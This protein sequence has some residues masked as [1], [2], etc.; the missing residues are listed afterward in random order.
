MASGFLNQFLDLLGSPLGLLGLILGLVTV[1]RAKHSPRLAWFLVALCCFAASLSEFRDQFVLDA[2]DLVFPLEQL[3]SAG[4]PLSIVLLALLLWLSCITLSYK[5]WRQTFIPFAVWA[6]ATIQGLIFFK[7]AAFGSITFALLAILTFSGVVLM[8]RLGPARW[9]QDNHQFHLGVW[10]IATVSIIFLAVNGYQAL[11]DPYPITFVH[12]AF[13]GTTGNP[14]HA[15][16]LLASTIPCILFLSQVQTQKLWALFWTILLICVFIALFLTGS[17]TGAIMGVLSIGL[18]FRHSNRRVRIVVPGIL[19]GGI[20][21]I[22]L[23]PLL[24]QFH[25]SIDVS[26][27]TRQLLNVDN[28]RSQVWTALWR[29][30][31]TYPVFGIPLQGDRFSGYGENSWLAVASVLGMAGLIPLFVFGVSCSQM[32]FKLN[33]IAARSPAYAMSSNVVIAGLSAL[34]VGSIFEA[35]LLGT[36][37]FPLITLLLYLALGQYLIEIHADDRFAAS[38]AYLSKPSFLAVSRSLK[39]KILR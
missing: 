12:G 15:A 13:L 27:V 25:T 20:L 37:T 30:F 28:T 3:R 24:G 22:V 10:A 16:T 4:R 2:P 21:C 35:F 19:L 8:V 14:Q 29:N 18:F 31:S 34:L 5:S 17:R 23:I 39:G 38:N 32:I 9:L 7:V 26:S 6:L 1:Y 11:F 33:R 36:I